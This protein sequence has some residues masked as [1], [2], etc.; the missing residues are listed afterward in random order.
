MLSL[1]TT[2]ELFWLAVYWDDF[3]DRYG[4][5]TYMEVRYFGVGEQH[6]QASVWVPGEPAVVR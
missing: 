1:M 6:D 5:S 3:L 2:E 4:V